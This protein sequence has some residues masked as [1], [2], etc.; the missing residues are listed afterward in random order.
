MERDEYSPSERA[1]LVKLAHEA[2]ES[3]LEKRALSLD[4]PSAHLAEPRGAFTTIY[5]EGK[6]RGCVGYVLPVLPVY[7]AVAETALAA[8][9]QDTRFLPVSLDE[10]RRLGVSLS[11]LSPLSP[12]EPQQI[13][14]GRH[15]LVVTLGSHRG[16]L[17]P[18]VPVEHHWDRST[19][20]EQTCR[21]AGL[22][23][24]AWKTGALLASFTAEVF[25]D[26][27]LHS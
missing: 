27:D 8:A 22:P 16:L 15:G 19:F 6:L 14:V 20:L 2:I 1:L 3:E 18:Q 21:K 12:I 24:D 10:A 5:L 4:P 17:L 7:R 9:S 11:I 23:A 13:E 25:G 26:S